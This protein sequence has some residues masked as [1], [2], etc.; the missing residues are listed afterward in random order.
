MKGLYFYKLT[1]PY[2]EDVTKECKLTVNEIDHNF[3]TL[4]NTDIQDIAFDEETGLLTL[5]QINGD[6]FIAKIDL[7]HFTRDFNVEWDKENSALIFNFDGKEV[8][9]DEFISTIVDNSVTNIVEEIISQTITDNTLVGVGVG[10][11]PLGINPLEI[12]G[13]YRAVERVINKIEGEYLPN[14]DYLKKGDRFL[15]YEKLNL[16]G[17]LY[18]FD[19]VKK[20]NEDVK[21]GWRVPTKADWDNMLNAIELCDNNKNHSSEICNVDAGKFAGKLLKYNNYWKVIDGS[22]VSL[23]VCDDGCLICEGDEPA[24]NPD[25]TKGVDA[26]GFSILPAG[27]GDGHG[28]LNYMGELSEFWSL[29]ETER[30]DVYT[31]RFYYNKTSVEQIAQTPN[32]L[33]S[34][35]LV[36][37]YDGNNFKGV[38]TINGM[39]YQTVLM[40]S[41]NTEHGYAIWIASNVGFDN[42]RY[43]PVSYDNKEVIIDETAFYINEWN[44]FYW[45]KKRLMEGDSVVIKTGPDGDNDREYRLVN[46]SLVNVKHD[47]KDELLKIVDALDCQPIENEGNYIAS[48]SQNNGVISATTKTLVKEDDRLLTYSNDGIFTTIDVQEFEGNYENGVK[49]VYKL[50]DKNEEPIGAPIII[51]ESMTN[52]TYVSTDIPV[53]GGPLAPLVEGTTQVISAG[54]NIQDLLFTLF[55][56]EKYPENPQFNKGSISAQIAAPSF[57]VYKTD[58]I[59]VLNNNVEIETGTKIDINSVVCSKSVYTVTDSTWSGFDYGYSIDNDNTKDGDGNPS[60]LTNTTPT[61]QT[62]Y[63]LNRTFTGFDNKISTQ[64]ATNN[65]DNTKVSVNKLSGIVIGDND[66]IITAYVTGATYSTTFSDNILGYYAC[67]NLK[68]T[69]QEKYVSGQTHTETTNTPTNSYAITIKGRRYSFVGALANNNFNPTSKDIRTS[70]AKCAFSKI[71]TNKVTG[72]S[73]NTCVV[74]AYPKEWGEIQQIKD[75][76]GMNAP[77]LNNFYKMEV[78]VEGANNY[79]A[80]PYYVYMFKSD[81]VLGAIDYDIIF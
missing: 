65:E 51:D 32:A 25:S 54:T 77:I 81:V 35:R 41:E 11:N 38:E 80:K 1:S 67:S 7:S 16:Y 56:Q 44:G 12:P 36:K 17:N 69:K 79:T 20:I 64:N 42:E 23:S 6:K 71:N 5:S 18:N 2:Q 34:L 22:D 60:K 48:V 10:K 50:V 40:P 26:Y 55:C 15:T 66:N 74:I 33:C 63:F 61:Q 30:T 39:N 78:D 29:T 46:D 59:T 73:G 28:I 24:F 13:T 47:L 19:A 3:V 53:A 21:D 31:K 75:V 45:M 76:N 27:Y 57:Q 37:D 43:N 4:K 62:N 72:E 9:I 8:K 49:K 52:E 68:N 58:T 14:E 70:L